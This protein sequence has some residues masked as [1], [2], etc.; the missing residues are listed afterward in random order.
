MKVW[1]RNRIFQIINILLLSLLTLPVGAQKKE[2]SQAREYIKKGTNID[3]AEQSMRRLLNDSVNRKNLKIWVTLAEAVRKQYEQGNEKLYLK[4]KYDTAALFVSAKKMFTVMEQIDSIETAR[5]KG[6][7]VKIKYRDKNADYLHT[8]RPNLYNGGLFYIRKQQFAEAYDFMD[9]YINCADLPLFK[10]YNYLET[11]TMMPQA[12]YWAVYC[13]YKMKDPKATLHHTY[14]A[15][16]DTAHYVLML[17]YL[18]E[19]YKIEK[20]TAR[21]METLTEGFDK[22]PKF[23]FFFPRLIEYYSKMGEWDKALWITNRA[24]AVDQQ[25][26]LFRYTKS[27]L[28]LNTG[29]YAECI[30]ICDSLISQDAQM[31][32]PYLNAGLAYFNQALDLDKSTA[33]SAKRQQKILSLYQKSLPYLEK[34]RQ[35]APDQKEKWALPLYTVYLNLNKGK[36]FDEI[37]QLMRNK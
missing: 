22:Y 37:D 34:Y 27:S 29:H 18:A 31:V 14:L 28:L 5:S 36:E 19:T 33:V 35:L 30:S 16:K 21:Y 3:K 13:G 32:E 15:L 26:V 11:D 7:K 2:I 4:Q 20:D 6:G 10:Q 9:A 23:P 12:A 25:N 8:Y 17:Q 1:G 24:L